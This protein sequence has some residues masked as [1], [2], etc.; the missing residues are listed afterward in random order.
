MQSV[1]DKLDEAQKA[2]GKF[3]LLVTKRVKAKGQD[4]VTKQI[5]RYNGLISKGKIGIAKL[6]DLTKKLN[7]FKAFTKEE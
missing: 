6:D 5:E 2:M 3:Y 7:I 4:F 1:I